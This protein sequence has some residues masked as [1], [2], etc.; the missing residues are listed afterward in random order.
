[1]SET[2]T[3]TTTMTIESAPQAV[4]VDSPPASPMPAR[5]AQSETRE[6]LYKLA[7]QLV[8]AGNRRLLIEYLRLRRTLR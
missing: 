4:V 1:M 5:D 2:T 3:T 6:Q 7:A 8:R